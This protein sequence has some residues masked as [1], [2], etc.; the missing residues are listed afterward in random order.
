MNLQNTLEYI[1]SV[2][3]NHPLINSS[4]VGSIYDLNSNTNT[5]YAVFAV[6]D[7]DVTK[8]NNTLLY[9]CY[10]YVVDRVMND[11]SN[12]IAVQTMAVNTLQEII[13]YIEGYSQS[14]EVYGSYIITPIRQKFSD[15]CAGAYVQLKFVSQNDIGECAFSD[16]KVV[17][18][19]Q[20]KTYLLDNYFT[21]SETLTLLDG[22]QDTLIAGDNITI[23][24]NVISAT[25]GGDSVWEKD[26]NNNIFPKGNTNV[27]GTNNFVTGLTSKA[28]H[29]NSVVIGYN[30]ESRTNNTVVIGSNAKDYDTGGDGLG[31][32]NLIAIGNNPV[33]PPRSLNTPYQTWQ[34]PKFIVGGLYG[35]QRF[36]TLE[37]TIN[38]DLYI[39]GI[40]GWTGTNATPDGVSHLQG[41]LSGLNTRISDNTT[42][43]GGKQN[44][45]TAGDNIEI[46]NDVISVPQE[47]YLSSVFSPEG[48]YG[49]ELSFS[50]R[51]QTSDYIYM[52]AGGASADTNIELRGAGNDNEASSIYINAY[53]YS[54]ANMQLGGGGETRRSQVDINASGYSDGVIQMRG[55]IEND[56]KSSIVITANGTEYSEIQITGGDENNLSHINIDS[57]RFTYNDNDVAVKPIDSTFD[58]GDTVVL[59]DNYIYSGSGI[60]SLTINGTNFTGDC[61]VQFTTGSTTPSITIS[62]LVFDVLPTFN[63]NKYYELG[64]HN[65]HCLWVEYDS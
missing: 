39:R 1:A 22:K 24:D 3:Q 15:E 51:T 38:G 44:T 49:S 36:N 16:D 59:T 30:C 35:F 2:A 25:G 12:T 56:K 18:I 7:I 46:E 41:Y 33:I 52:K 47:V 10:L 43:I 21:K 32:S 11:E 64:I 8:Q 40:N 57:Q 48:T 37:Q 27:T 50:A 34:N 55:G 28:D 61:L 5:K 62:G 20:G 60:A 58:S 4:F 6:E 31:W 17:E 42:A 9:N 54:D 53:G 29:T 65:G 45:L 63:S 19:F 14:L 23:V 26:A 13:N